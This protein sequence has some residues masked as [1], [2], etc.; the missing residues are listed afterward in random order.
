MSE[1]TPADGYRL[2]RKNLS[3][4]EED[5]KAQ[6]KRNAKKQEEAEAKLKKSY[7]D[8]LAET[9][10]E[11]EDTVNNLRKNY[12]GTADWERNN[13]RAELEKQRQ[14]TYDRFGRANALEN[15][16]VKQQLAEEIRAHEVTRDVGRKQL[17]AIEDALVRRHQSQL[18]KQQTDAE[19]SL[20]RTQSS[21]NEAFERRAKGLKDDF[22]NHAETL[23]NR[24]EIIDRERNQE[25][26]FERKRM[27]RDLSQQTA[28]F[29]REATRL[30][31][32]HERR[33][34]KQA[35]GASEATEK[36]VFNAKSSTDRDNARL[37]RE[38]SALQDSET[39]LQETHAKAREDEIRGQEEETRARER[40]IGE[41]YGREIAQLKRSAKEA[42]A[43]FARLQSEA[44]KDKDQHFAQ[45]IRRQAQENAD[46]SHEREK[47][48]GRAFNELR[49]QQQRQ[50]R[51][52]SKRAEQTLQ[53]AEGA[54]AKALEQQA[55]AGRQTLARQKRSDAQTISGL[56]KS[57]QERKTS[58]RPSEVLS[59]SAEKAIRDSILAEQQ[60]VTDE[61]I[62]RNRKAV[63]SIQRSYSTWLDEA[64]RDA[65]TRQSAQSRAFA[66]EK[67]E[68]QKSLVDQDRQNGMSHEEALK[69]M[70]YET[71]RQK[72]AMGRSYAHSLD[73][74]QRH[75]EGIIA[76]MRD[77]A[78]SKIAAVRQQA[79][80]DSKMAN[81]ASITRQ[82]ELIR[83]YDKKLI[84]QKSA[85]QLQLDELKVQTANQVRDSEKRSKLLTDE[86]A[87]NFE[88]RIAQVE[89]QH[90]ERERALVEKYE[91]E[92][93]KVRR[94][95]AL[96]ASKKS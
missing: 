50:E 30:E 4:L 69:N 46:Q 95:N 66:A 2:Y 89:A 75:Y 7:D 10:R 81:R 1:I 19:N 58:S 44:L 57:L 56:E 78:N 16:P 28:N 29:D 70:N 84:E 15:G 21:L 20:E 31:D 77:D 6:Q 24:F 71:E 41:S 80:F 11:H 94:S 54:G 5:T 17:Q 73:R 82:N 27:E 64:Q 55:E 88:Q 86:Q 93:D 61:D 96:L 42:D 85:Y 14:A 23:R 59:P 38:M 26:N 36:A 62:A 32:L 45:V 13:S 91:E 12:Q 47:E 60:K 49:Q 33:S 53:A 18:E 90:K 68:L 74:T 87:R 72:E 43:H 22:E 76:E 8:A 35:R 51:V 34:D 65:E 9:R 83:E 52:E 39:R 79:E 92:L 63:D 3:E 67:F 25:F 40:L 48:F 37:R